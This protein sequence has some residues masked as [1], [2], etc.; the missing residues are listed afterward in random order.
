MKDLV[1][2]LVVSDIL[3]KHQ[4]QLG[5]DI[6][7][8][9][10]AR[11]NISFIS[12]SL[13]LSL[14]LFLTTSPSLTFSCILLPLIYLWWS[15]ITYLSKDNSTSLF[16]TFSLQLILYQIYKRWSR[17]N[18]SVAIE[19]FQLGHPTPTLPTVSTSQ[20]LLT[21]SYTLQFMW[22][23]IW[24]RDKHI[25]NHVHMSALVRIIL[26]V[27]DPAWTIRFVDLLGWWISKLG[28]GGFR[29]WSLRL[30]MSQCISYRTPFWAPLSR[31]WLTMGQS[32]SF[33]SPKTSLYLGHSSSFSRP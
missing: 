16:P 14:S 15:W 25:F 11:M 28:L 9:A 12:F 32:A 27:A 6:L 3:L 2:V 24:P 22:S 26:P 8:W 20:F 17:K 5:A 21:T 23:H 19:K 18:S 33:Q 7:P 13:P 29:S 31:A 10:A 30:S 1:W 4:H